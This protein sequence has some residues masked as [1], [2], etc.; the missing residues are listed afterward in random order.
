M[1]SIG[2]VTEDKVGKHLGL[3]DSWHIGE[4]VVHPDNE[5]I[6]YVAVLGHFWSRNKNRGIYRTLDGGESWEHVLYIND[7]TGGNDIV[8]SPS[9]PNIL[10]ASMW[11]FN[12]DS[13]LFESVYGPNSSIHKS[14]DAGKTWKKMDSGL[15]EGP[16]K[17]R[18]GLAVSYSNPDK[19][20]ALMDNLNN[21]RHVAAEIYGTENGGESWNRTHDSD[22]FFASII[23]WYFMDIYVNPKNDKEVFALGVR[24]AHS[25]DG[26]KSFT[27]L[28]GKVKHIN[29]SPT[30]TLHLDHCELWINPEKP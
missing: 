8:I 17:G 12:P 16:K 21:A 11:E 30:Q 29:Q 10:Y 6:V 9:D 2:R 5:D 24:V 26:G 7:Q 1:A 22:L 23:G 28:E 4:I 15:P 25:V 20:Y 27:Y 19:V 14:V 13:T 18:I 3:S